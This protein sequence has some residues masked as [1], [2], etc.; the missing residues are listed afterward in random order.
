MLIS[1]LH[2]LVIRLNMLE[3]QLDLDMPVGNAPSSV[4]PRW[5]LGVGERDAGTLLQDYLGV[6]WNKTFFT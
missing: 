3:E 2:Y 1:S 4:F 5:L 6:G